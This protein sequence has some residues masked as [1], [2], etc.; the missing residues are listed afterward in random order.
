MT[1]SR[2]RR[3]VTALAG[4]VLFTAIAGQFWRNLLGYWG[5]GAVALAAVGVSVWMLAAHRPRIRFRRIPTSLLVFTGLVVL[6]VVWS[7]YRA[8]TALGILLYLAVFAAAAFVAL[9][10]RWGEIVAALAGALRWTISLSL[11]FELYVAIFVR[12]PLPPNFTDYG[13]D[14][15]AAFF[16]SR[17]LLFAGGPIEGIVGSRNL[18]GFAA[19]LLVVL[20]A[21]QFASGLVRPTA[22]TGWLVASALVLALTRS[23][24]VFVAAAAVLAALGFAVW[25]RRISPQRRRP[26]YWTAAGLG[27]AVLAAVALAWPAILQAFGKSEDLTG[28]FDIWASVW[29]MIAEKPWFGWGWLGYWQP[30]VEP[31]DDLAVRNGVVYLQAHNAW[32]DV[33]MQLGIL[34]LIAFAALAIGTLWRSWF[35]A[36]DRPHDPAGGPRPYQAI[37]LLPLALTVALLAQSI[38]ESRILIEGGLLL[39]LVVAVVTKQRQWRPEPLP[40]EAPEPRTARPGGWNAP[41]GPAAGSAG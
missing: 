21:L 26:V 9:C 25:M 3:L 24:T 36:V 11:L 35:L 8:G 22:G 17:D 41:T 12:A 29:S 37:A 7:S 2:N 14:A 27:A 34:G 1:A 19:L 18:L 20:T 15:P 4:F 13:D 38:A 31:F 40:A 23:A 10:L 6:S 32:L 33:W 5:W 16:W 39:F 30:W 28:R